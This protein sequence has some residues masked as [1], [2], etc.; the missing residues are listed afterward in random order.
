MVIKQDIVEAMERLGVKKS[1]TIIVHS[2]MKSFG[3]V[4]AGYQT[5][6]DALK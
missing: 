5:V 6:L 3:Y 4:D 1:D 2:S